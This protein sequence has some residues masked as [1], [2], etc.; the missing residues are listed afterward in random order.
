MRKILLLIFL[1]MF[2][3]NVKAEYN[4]TIIS[5]PP[6][7]DS[8]KFIY[9]DCI[10]CSFVLEDSTNN[11]ITE[12]NINLRGSQLDYN[13]ISMNISNESRYVFTVQ[14]VFYNTAIYTH[15]TLTWSEFIPLNR[16]ENFLYII[17]HDFKI[18]IIYD[19]STSNTSFL[20]IPTTAF[21][22]RHGYVN[23]TSFYTGM[24]ATSLDVLG[25]SI[26]DIE[27]KVDNLG[28]KLAIID[29]IKDL[30]PMSYTIY[31]VLTLNGKVGENIT[32]LT[33]LSMIDIF[34]LIMSIFFNLF[35]TYPYLLG[36]YILTVGNFYVL[37]KMHSVRDIVN[38]YFEYFNKVISMFSYI[39]TKIMEIIVQ[40][41]QLIKRI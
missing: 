18:N 25:L 30:S 9:H 36:V 29:R 26:Y 34:F 20:A 15:Q 41:L 10:A 38:Y 5:I 35:Y 7:D 6:V 31:K 4:H 11:A 12:I 19:I 8:E 40:I 22:L 16:S 1:I 21:S 3:S 27:I 23:E 24:P 13:G 28:E 33:I 14:R 32:L 39:F 2:I 37:F 17:P